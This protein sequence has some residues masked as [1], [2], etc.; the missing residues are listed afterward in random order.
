MSTDS[1]PH[2]VE[3]FPDATTF[4]LAFVLMTGKYY[5]VFLNSGS[6]Q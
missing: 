4:A 1:K 6:L 3:I 2:L 5:A